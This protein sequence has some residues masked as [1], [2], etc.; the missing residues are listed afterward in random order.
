M[1]STQEHV[2]VLEYYTINTPAAQD[3]LT[4]AA[5]VDLYCDLGI[6]THQRDAVT[7]VFDSEPEQT[8]ALVYLSCYAQFTVHTG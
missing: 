6:D 3:A 8:M 7:L 1:S 4:N 5:A 2:L